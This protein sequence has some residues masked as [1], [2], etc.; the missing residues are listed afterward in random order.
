M[1][2]P[3]WKDDT[4]VAP[5]L[6]DELDRLSKRIGDIRWDLKEMERSRDSWRDTAIILGCALAAIA[7]YVAWGWWRA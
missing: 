7:G 1:S 3:A 2:V 6:I 5:S 4:F